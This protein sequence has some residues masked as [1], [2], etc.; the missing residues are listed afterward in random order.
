MLESAVHV[1]LCGQVLHRAG[2]YAL[3]LLCFRFKEE[4]E[5]AIAELKEQVAGA[6][7]ERHALEQQAKDQVWLL[8][9]SQVHLQYF[10][11]VSQT[12]VVSAAAVV[13]VFQLA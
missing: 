10:C 7:Q 9:M 5:G 1:V 11:H 3:R 2:Q 12:C 4:A 6:H 13:I 8:C